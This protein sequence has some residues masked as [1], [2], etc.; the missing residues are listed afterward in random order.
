MGLEF[1]SSEILMSIC[2][3]FKKFFSSISVSN[4]YE[5]TVH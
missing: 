3:L 5:A 2:M 1:Q 4:K